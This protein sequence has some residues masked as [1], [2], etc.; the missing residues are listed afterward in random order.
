MTE[1]VFNQFVDIEKVR[2]LLLSHHALT[3]MSYTILDTDE[4]ILVAVGWQDICVQFHRMNP[5]SCASCRE[6]DAYIKSHLHDLEKNVIEYRCKNG[7]I[8]VAMPI[9]IEGEHLATFFTGQFFY[10]D[11]RPDAEFFKSQAEALGFDL[12]AYLNALERVPVFSRETVRS[13]MLFMYEMVKVL[14]RIGLANLKLEREIEER[15]RTEKML[16]AREQE[17]R[18]LAENSPDNIVRYDRQCRAIYFNSVMIRKLPPEHTNIL[19]KTPVERAGDV[20]RGYE[21]VLRQVLETGVPDE[22]ELFL[23]VPS[24]G[25]STH[26]IRF[27]AERDQ[28]GDITGVLAF[29][30]DITERRH[31]EE[32]LH[33]R[34]QAFRSLAE[35]SRDFIFRYDRN[36]RRTY[37]N[38]AVE[39]FFGKTAET[40]L[41][42]TPDEVM[43]LDFMNNSE[44]VRHIR[45]VLASGRAMEIELS[46]GAPDGLMHHFLCSYAPEWGQ[47]GNVASVLA[48]ARDITERKQSEALL[49][50]SEFFFKESQRS[51]SIGSYKVDFTTGYWESSE[52]LD[53]IFGIDKEYNR[54]VQGWLDIVH[55]ADREMMGQYL[56]EEVIS[57]RNPFSKEYRI[58]RKN[59][60]ETRWVHGLGQVKIDGN[61]N[62]VSMFGTIQDITERKRGEL[63]QQLNERRMSSLYEISQYPFLNESEFLDH[64]LHE[65]IR[66]TESKIGYIYFYNE[67]QRQF[68]LNTW[69]KDVMKECMVL[70]QKTIYDLDNTGIWGEAVRQKKPIIVNNFEV[71]HPLKKGY[72]EGHVIL[73]RFLTIPVIANDAIVAVVGVANKESGYSNVDVMQ[74]TL[75]M[76]SVWKIVD[77][78]RMEEAHQK[79]EK[80]LQ[81]TQKLESLGILAGGIAHDFNNILVAIIGNADLALMK[82]NPESPA[83]N[84]L[85]KIEQA[86][87]RAA[88][89]AKQMLA[90]SGKGKFVIEH[91]DMNRVLEEMVYML[92][93]SMSK[94]IALRLNLSR[95]LPY[96]EADITQIHQVIMNLIINASEAIG[97]DSGVITI[98]TSSVDCDKDYLSGIAPSEQLPEGTYVALEIVDTGCGMDQDTMAKIFDPF[99]TTKF[100]G[101]GLG[102]AAVHGIIKGHKGAI[103]VYSEPGKGS[104][105]KILLPASVATAFPQPVKALDAEWHGSGV[106]LLVDDEEG[107]RNVGRDMLVALGFEVVTANDGLDALEILK[108]NQSIKVIILDL[109]MPRMDGEQVFNELR[110]MNSGVSVIMS[111]GYNEQEVAQKFVGK[112]LAGF[113]Q[114]PYRMSV[115]REVL[116]GI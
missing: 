96:I 59:D 2:Q 5:V 116:A 90:Y 20:M 111:S 4:N 65:L 47:D 83:T 26:H 87:S 69:S 34:E 91:T 110:R 25:L 68:I 112:R 103:N 73:E 6:S 40:L 22:F 81:H 46:L 29:G 38:P 30:R 37:V 3:G 99:F 80:Q 76:D 45:D 75:F 23:A 12:E 27:V 114:K 33:A 64:T 8:D 61:G 41:G 58:T 52:V 62:V 60:Y 63:E 97:D 9:I 44:H 17:Y 24:G 32:E 56:R 74:L 54:S 92:E 78:K 93:V 98:I 49:I 113:I 102:M 67:K 71:R 104:I 86:A 106:I 11:E 66:L 36:C 108:H 88:D 89:L 13:N 19:G 55:S 109:T 21:N 77:R 101:R 70:E 28:L 82:I 10:E 105:F 14:A 39:R 115:L 1:Y 31:M 43:V 85:R 84:N 35:N 48:T 18:T 100:T 53:I 7:M 15:K 94:K 107:V 79:L 51:A 95:P 72:P 50:E 16:I 42:K 57:K